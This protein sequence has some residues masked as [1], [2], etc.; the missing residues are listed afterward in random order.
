MQRE[1]DAYYVEGIKIVIRAFA[2]YLMLIA[3]NQEQLKVLLDKARSYLSWM[4]LKMNPS[5]TKL[6]PVHKKKR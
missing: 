6:M 5:K 1:S 4:G 2:D 3:K